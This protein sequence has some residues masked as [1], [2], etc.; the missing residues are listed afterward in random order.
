MCNMRTETDPN[1]TSLLCN[2]YSAV[3]SIVS[4]EKKKIL[5]EVEEVIAF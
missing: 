2:A 5:S 1:T 4:V 3:G